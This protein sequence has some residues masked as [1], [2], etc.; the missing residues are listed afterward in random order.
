M[1]CCSCIQTAYRYIGGAKWPFI[2]AWLLYRKAV[3]ASRAQLCIHSSIKHLSGAA[4][5]A[6]CDNAVKSRSCTYWSHGRNNAS[7]DARARHLENIA[8]IED[9]VH[10]G[11]SKHV[12]ADSALDKRAAIRTALTHSR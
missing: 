7:L 4:Q 5:H 12:R 2:R 11:A 3:Y 9:L 10:V 8:D 1:R 6:A